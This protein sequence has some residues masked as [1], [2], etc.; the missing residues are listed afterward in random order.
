MTICVPYNITHKTHS[1][2]DSYAFSRNIHSRTQDCGRRTDFPHTTHADTAANV[3]HEFPTKFYKA[4]AMAQNQGRRFKTIRDPSRSKIRPNQDARAGAALGVGVAL[5]VVRCCG[6]YC[7]QYRGQYW[8]RSR[9]CARLGVAAG[10]ILGVAVGAVVDAAADATADATVDAMADATADAAAGAVIDAV[11]D[12]GSRVWV[13]LLR[14]DPT[15]PDR[16][17]HKSWYA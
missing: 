17:W 1:Y 12:A 5:A 7:G 15:D 14:K 9:C 6:R 10:V 4:H 3:A 8:G 16:E 13:L 2:L 11:S